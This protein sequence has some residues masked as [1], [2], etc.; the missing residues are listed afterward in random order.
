MHRQAKCVTFL[1]A[2]AAGLCAC[3][4]ASP[5][6]SNEAAQERQS[7]A[8][9]ASVCQ[10][11]S[12]T[13]AIQHVVYIQFDNVHFK[14]DNPRVPSDLEQMP[15]LLHFITGGGTLLSNH[16]T[17]L[18]SHTADDI[19]TSLTG[20]YPSRHGQAVANSYAFFTPPGSK[21]FDGFASSFTYWTDLVNPVTN[22]SFNMITADG[23]NAPAP[24]VPYTRAGCNVGAV[25]IANIE[26]E[27]TRGDITTVFGPNSPEAQEAA[28]NPAQAN[29]D[30]VGIAVH[31]AAGDAVCSA[32]NGGVADVLHQEPRGYQGYSGLFGHKF[33]A[34]VIS[35]SGPLT[36][37]NG[38]PI[39]GFPGFGG[40]S[41]AQTLA[42][43]AAMQEHG[44]PITFA[45]ISDAHGDHTGAEKA[46]GPGEAG[47]VAQLA[48]YDHA[49]D[50]FFSR[51]AADGITPANTLFVVTSDE[52]DHFAGGPP[53]PPDCDGVSVPCTYTKIG[54]INANI[55]SLLGQ[56]DPSLAATPFD[57][58]F[59]MAPA[60]YI[61]GNQAAGTPVARAYERATAKLRAVS[62]IT[63]NTDT[64]T[65]ALADAA[66]L[67]LLHMVTGDPQRTPSFVM[68]GNPDYF[69]VT[70]GP[71]LLENPTFAWNHG[72]INP[73][74]TTTW[75][76]L[77]GP[78]VTNAGVSGDVF[79][80]HTDIRPT[81]LRLV[82]LT[83]DYV[84]DGRVLFEVL[85]RSALPQS[86]ESDDQSLRR[87]ARAYKAINAPLG[88]LALASLRISTAGLASGDATTDTKYQRAVA[89]LSNVTK[90]R[91][92]LAQDIIAALDAA[93][94][95]GTPI[96]PR[97]ALVWTLEADALVAI[98]EAAAAAF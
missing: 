74:I 50:V 17:P 34:P 70:S 7:Q 72:G 59:D 97:K 11:A 95:H 3:G 58:H 61:Q 98:V 92:A 75:L 2:A 93:E 37:L 46:F 18:I 87:L 29:A 43:V 22:P 4:E 90:V 12:S 39:A 84:A 53:S 33:V 24:W 5:H 68:F 19:V 76:G 35:P 89:F 55:T 44:V 40:I 20:V 71:D 30:F 65:L 13:G 45:Y 21:F 80:D 49:F 48:A 9:S 28:T 82:G 73:E 41:A 69:F 32:Q 78:G 51:L 1:V 36:D 26:L 86:L 23:K 79:S 52:D 56:V 96:D 60:F 27:N 6:R 38:H 88:P 94:F 8:L 57:I 67:R 42:Y 47:Y 81:M 15:H 63:G 31:C 85:D 10:L 64:L 77:V 83:D 91:D 16:H 25:S 66:E 54:E 62:P 14:R